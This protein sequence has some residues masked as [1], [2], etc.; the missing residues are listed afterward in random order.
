[1]TAPLRDPAKLAF[2]DRLTHLYNWW[3]MAQYLR[4]RFGWIA[5][6]KIPLSVI[7]LNLDDF[8][9]I[10]EAHG[11]LAGDI[12]LR[13]VGELLQEGRRRGGYA[14]RYAGDEFFLFLE[15][16]QADRAMGI[17]EEIRARIAAESIV[18][19]HAVSGIP[20]SA[21]LGVVTFPHEA[22]TA[23]G[24]V[25][26]V[27]RALAHAKRR[28]KNRVS[29]DAGERLPTEKEALAQLHRPRLLGR[30][31]ELELLKKVFEEA[32]S[33]RNR[34]T[35]IEGEHGL[36]K[37]RFL[38]ELP[39]LARSTGLR[40]L[41]GGCLPQNQAVPYAA[42]TPL[43]QEYFDRSPELVAPTTT[44]LSRPKLAALASLLPFLRTGKDETD[45]ISAPERRRQL[46]QGILDLFCLMS[47][48]SPLGVFLE[49]I[50]WADEAT[51]EVLLHL[52]SRDDGKVLVC[53]TA[54]TDA[55]PNISPEAKGRSLPSFLPFFQA[56]PRFQRLPLALLAMPQVG[57]LASDILRH[58][59]PARFQQ[60]LFQVSRG[61]PL[62]VEETLKS[63][64]TR[65]ALR[66]EEGAWNFEQVT[67]EDFPASA[68]EAIA[69]RLENLEPETLEVVSEASIIGPEVDLPVLAEV[70]GRDP[71][72]TLQ[73]V[74]RGRRS[75]VFEATDPVADPGE[76]RFSSARLRELVYDG[77]DA[78]HRRQSHRKVAEVYER[79]ASPDVDEAVGP[80]AYH[81]ERSDDAGKWSFYREKLR[82]LR[83]WLFSAADVGEPGR[84]GSG[85]GAAAA[86][87][88]AAAAGGGIGKGGGDESGT[89]KVRIP[90]A[91]QP[92]DE[93]VWPVAAA[94]TKTLTLACKN[95]RVFPEG[96]QLVRNE[97]AGATDTLLRLLEHLEGVTLAEHRGALL[98][99]GKTL[100]GK[101]IAALAQDLRRI[102]TERGI[103]SVTFVRGVVES[104]VQETLKILSGPP[105]RIPPEIAAWEKMLDSRG[106]LH[107][108]I[109][110]A[111][112]LAAGKPG[113]EKAAEEAPLDDE[114]MR[115]SAEVFRS[116]AGAV[117]NLRL[118]PPENELNIAIQDR[119]ERQ[120]QTLL[121][122]I[123][124]VTLALADDS[125]VINGARPNP[126][127]FGLTTPLLH[128][129]MRE[130]GLSSITLT[131]GVSRPDL[132]ILL[133]HLARQGTDDPATR[134]V[135]GQVL[136]ERGITTIQ[137]GSRFYA[138]ARGSL[139]GGGRS[140]EGRWSGAVTDP[141]GPA[142][143]PGRAS[144][145]DERLFEQVA[146]WL[147]TPGSAPGFREEEIPAA[148]DSLLGA[149]RGDLA[150]RLWDRI[151]AGLGDPL[152]NTR[153]RAAAALRLLLTR[154][155]ARTLAWLRERSMEPLEKA[156]LKET[157]PRIFE[158]QVRAATEALKLRLR[159]GD[160]AGSMGLAE[161]L[162]KGQLGKPDQKTLA[163]LAT[164]AVENLAATGALEPLLAALKGSDPAHREQS[165]AFLAALG[166]GGLQFV[167]KIVA[168][169]EDAEVRKVAATLLGSLP[170][171]GL[172]LLVPQLS[173]PTSPEVSRRIVSVLDVITPELGPDFSPLLSHPDVLVRAEFA[174]VVSRLPRAA[175]VK[176]LERA[177][178]EPQPEIVTGALECARGIGATELLDAI[179][180]LTHGRTP[181]DALKAC[182]LCL[183]KL[184]DQRAVDP[185]IQILRRRPR[186][187]GLV[188][189]LPETVRAAAARALGE[190]GFPE[191]RRAL[192][193][194][195]KDSSAA[196][197]STARLALSR[198]RPER[199]AQ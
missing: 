145:T 24:L 21:S 61:V 158:W 155:K 196:V 186:F 67:P 76:I 66:H 197:R 195:V 130:N 190:L 100:E 89:V 108:G 13:R 167:V 156:M 110:P 6:Q 172:R 45:E 36:G 18:V 134:P 175:G 73:L 10:N 20:V 131:Q 176:F 152:E 121:Q 135:L 78:A 38:A 111:I 86:P 184:K 37:S 88:A 174:G 115:L 31:L 157:S 87:A 183:G 27:R 160:L 46:F 77:V 56:S 17:A 147:D 93:N 47:E 22:Q 90:E 170:G 60:Q 64:I 126:K 51:L 143:V 122:R 192:R 57:D 26:K 34:F 125:I 177:L 138:P 41:Q 62:L 52:L 124:T 161:A 35:L 154:A 7:L 19:P 71:G 28:G 198:L 116:L 188:R 165:R 40:F 50:H 97:V 65:G 153:Q 113:A 8:R 106:V 117:D 33:G 53:A 181:P 98:V 179:V 11:R 12:V 30:E 137:V 75:G 140:G 133:S 189:G 127:W 91:S 25:E 151:M 164:T 173:P 80:I 107:V 58:P 102:F 182:C 159:E 150:Q 185:L 81:Y 48:G 199:E 85:T 92:L 16:V 95:M 193:E 119:L 74:D 72:E 136:E 139:V 187:L 83:D 39:G 63:L 146:Q 191:A 168:R 166:E 132:R 120:A 105:Q 9:A 42:L 169:E 144:S 69:R 79:Q 14:V 44:R 123:S 84:S 142:A 103:R 70:L 178:A 23:S 55:P 128:K 163:P 68:D 129:L 5:A 118:Y 104:E 4:E 149:E 141:A 2:L 101:A 194:A 1:M 96:S 82:A 3:F 109:F 49:N 171:R 43:L 32:P 15:G 114:A 94:F 59:I 54:L 99:N 29:R 180:R 162:G 148:L 112:Y